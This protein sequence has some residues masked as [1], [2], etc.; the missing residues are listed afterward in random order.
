M[1]TEYLENEE[2]SK[3]AW[4]E[5]SESYSTEPLFMA[6][7]FQQQTMVSQLIG[8]LAKYKE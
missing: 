2:Y 1:L 5:V 4:P 7:I 6:L 8:R 3:A